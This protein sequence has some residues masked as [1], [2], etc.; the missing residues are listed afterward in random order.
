MPFEAIMDKA[1][2]RVMQAF[3][4]YSLGFEANLPT[5]LAEVAKQLKPVEPEQSWVDPFCDFNEASDAIV[6][7]YREVAEK[8]AFGGGLLQKWVVDSLLNSAKVHIDLLENPPDG[9]EPFLNN[10]D[11]RLRWVLH[12]SAFFFR[13]QTEFPFHYANEACAELAVLGM[14]LLRGG[15]LASAGACGDAIRSIALKSARAENSKNYTSAYGFADCVVKL[16]LLARAAD[17]FDWPA[18]AAAFRERGTR[19]EGIMDEGLLQYAKAVATRTRQ[20]EEELRQ[21][22]RG[23]RTRP[24]PVAELRDIHRQSRGP[25]TV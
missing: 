16:E 3:P 2:Q 5:L 6:H 11:D 22:D 21:R 18:I 1:G 15:R 14:A 12:A 25:G 13:E 20:M 7:H 24:D 17:A 10:V 8:I 19:P 4:P 23:Y 9:A